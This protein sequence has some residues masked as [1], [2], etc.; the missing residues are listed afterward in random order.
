VS[1]LHA[2]PITFETDDGTTHS[3][4]VH[5]VVNGVGTRLVLDT[6][7]SDHILT[8]D[9]CEAANLATEPG[10]P[11]TDS[12]GSSV[13]SWQARE[14]TI[15][16]GA[17]ELALDEVIAI[18]TPPPFRTRGLGGALSP[19]RLRPGTYAVLDL[20][21]A[22]VVTLVPAD[23]LDTWLAESYPGWHT[24]RLPAFDGDG[25]V[26]VEAA[27]DSFPPVV[28]MLDTGAKKTYAARTAVPGLGEGGVLRSTGR[29]V[30]GTEA[31]GVDV[32]GRMLHVGDTAL[33]V[34]LVVA[35]HDLGIP[36]C[37]VGMDV[38]RGTV[39]AVGHPG[40]AVLWL[41]PR[42]MVD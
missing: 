17:L 10:E 8:I 7:A 14:V 31:F 38:L 12:T 42:G 24:N 20:S 2:E 19:Q 18:D 33:P 5:A 1:V 29:G 34:N 6:G 15:W 30:G 36:A 13:P 22:P 4:L 9:V 26:L 16:I 25:T 28:V 11:G 23:D 21:A 37:V 41:L 40:S 27:I 3:P 32:P 39:L 35:E